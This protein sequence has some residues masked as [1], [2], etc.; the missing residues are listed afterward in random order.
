MFSVFS[1]FNKLKPPDHSLHIFFLDQMNFIC[2]SVY[3]SYRNKCH[4]FDL[5]QK[6]SSSLYNLI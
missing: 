4:L 2:F 3:K 6:C 5:S 1:Y